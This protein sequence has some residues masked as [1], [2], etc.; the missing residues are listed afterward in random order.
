[1]TIRYSLQYVLVGIL[2]LGMGFGAP[3]AKAETHPVAISL[4]EIRDL[5]VPFPIKSYEPG[6]RDLVR[7]QT[8]GP[9]KVTVTGI[10]EGN[11]DLKVVGDGDQ[12]EIFRIAV[13][14]SADAVL[15]EV[16]KDLENIPGI[17]A[18]L[19][20]G[21]V[22][23]RG[24]VTKPQDWGFLKRT[25]LPSYG[26][27]VQCRVVFRLQDELLLKLKSNLEKSHF[28]VIEG[29]DVSKDPGTLSLFS[30]E[31]NVIINGSVYSRGEFDSVRSVVTA[32]PWLKIRKDGD[33]DSDD[34][35][36]AVINVTVAPV[37]LEL[38]VTFVGVTDA[39][40]TTLGA[41]LLRNGL[42]TVY[43]TA[44]IAGSAVSGATAKSGSYVVSGTMSDTL[45]ALNTGLGPGRF[46]SMG[47]LTFKNDATDWKMFQDGGTI[48]LPITGGVGGNVGVQPI[49]YGLII[50]AKGGLSDAQN[51]SMDLQVEMSVPV[52]AG[53][54]PAGPIYNLHRSRIDSTILC[55]VGKTLIM[56]GTK[57]LTE[58][59]HIDSETPGLGKIPV[60]K[61]LF[62][63]RTKNREDRQV[64]I[65][66]S[67]Q[68]AKAP[69][70][71]A[72][73][74]DQTANTPEKAAKP[75]SI[76]KH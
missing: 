14:S 33:K 57:Q 53:S 22:V 15:K 18:E 25:V 68:I 34:T 9:Q 73:V 42:A 20:L 31:N 49:D 56:G 50:K 51:A 12:V 30:S 52:P 36:Y 13:Q 43:A 45:K 70:V 66:I 65:L 38:D 47:H 74:S 1:M 61:F 23:L 27:Q 2:T 69:T 71:S 6:N 39:E 35:C 58:G 16:R 19:S 64:L 24:V 32:C 11:T 26:D 76:M 48:E 54:S 67:P 62:S 5:S 37:L 46:S 3:A 72:P 59:V 60:L 7:V 10:K 29:N 28:K 55:P 63:E 21:K 40:N 17:E 8:S 75:L 4:G 44:G 41:N